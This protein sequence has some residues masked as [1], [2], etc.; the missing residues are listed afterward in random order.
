MMILRRHPITRRAV[1]GLLAAILGLA[2]GGCAKKTESIEEVRT[3]IQ[4]QIDKNLAAG[5]ARDSAA[6]WSIFTDDYSYRGYDGR[7]VERAEAAQSYGQSL[8]R[9]LALKEET[10]VYIDSLRVT[11]DTAIVY[12]KQHV[13]RSEL[14]A[15]SLPHLTISNVAHRERWVKTKDGWKIQY[16]EELSIGPVM[17]DGQSYDLDLSGREFMRAFWGGGL[18]SLR[19]RYMEVRS[20]HP[21]SV[22][23]AEITLKNL[24]RTLLATG[25]MMDA[26]NVF[27]MNADAH[28]NSPDAYY[29]LAEAYAVAGQKDLAVKSLRRSLKLDPNNQN[30]RELLKKL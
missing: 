8:T 30:A 28:P 14:G 21:D 13:A 27:A 22:P 4:A 6:F 19:V 18:D 29:S 12:T 17:V 23:F 3:A 11:G 16:L 2:F 24:G 25:K 15:D 7:V 1:A 9:Q 20:A 5:A 10:K 26:I